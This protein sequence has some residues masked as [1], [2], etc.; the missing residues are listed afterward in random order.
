[1]Q[2][3]LLEEHG[4]GASY[5]QERA[6]LVGVFREQDLFG[7]DEIGAVSFV[8]EATTLKSCAYS[9]TAQTGEQARFEGFAQSE[10]FFDL[11]AATDDFEQPLIG[12]HPEASERYVKIVVP[13]EF[14]LC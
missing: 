14:V 10:Y 7:L 11:D 8:V 6:L 4:H 3:G 13:E 9:F 12:V 2:T 1:L 5:L